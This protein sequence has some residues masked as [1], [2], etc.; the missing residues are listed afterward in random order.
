[1]PGDTPKPELRMAAA[2]ALTWLAP[3]VGHLFIGERARGIIFLVVISITFW[4]GIAVGGVKNTVDP[5][6][7]RLWFMGQICAGGHTLVAMQWS[8]LLPDDPRL[9]AFGHEE[10]I[11][12]VYTAVCGMLN[13]LV[14]FDVLT[15]CERQSAVVV[16]R[17]RKP[18]AN[19]AGGKGGP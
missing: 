5:E 18:P 12:V 13:I 3:G 4:T 2:G 17:R 10:E 6:N 14:I 11:S 19:Q 8:N 16:E 15:R 9:K 1:M 7:R